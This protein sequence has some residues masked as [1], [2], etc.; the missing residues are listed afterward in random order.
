LINKNN[1]KNGREI[2]DSHKE[3]KRVKC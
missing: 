2:N 3:T 1:K